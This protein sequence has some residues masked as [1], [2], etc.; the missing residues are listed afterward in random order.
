MHV[1]R[2]RTTGFISLSQEKHSQEILARFNKTDVRPISTPALANERL[3]KLAEAQVDIK[4]YQSALGALM[5]PMIGS[6]PDLAYAVGARVRCT[7]AQS[8]DLFMFLFVSLP[9]F[10]C[11]RTPRVEHKRVKKTRIQSHRPQFHTH[12]TEVRA[13]CLFLIAYM[14]NI[15]CSLDRLF[16]RTGRVLCD[17]V[18]HPRIMRPG[19]NP[20]PSAYLSNSVSSHAK[21]RGSVGVVLCHMTWKC[22]L[23]DH[24]LL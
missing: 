14:T 15:S 2:D 22:G 24:T 3:Q 23:A 10:S 9:F 5:Y 21:L 8:P 13:R 20:G 6:R 17:I 19:P 1:V 4:T 16:T 12:G 11:T 18:L 7:R